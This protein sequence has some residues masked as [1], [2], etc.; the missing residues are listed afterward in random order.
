MYDEQNEVDEKYF[1]ANI[2]TGF[3]IKK[4]KFIQASVRK[5]LK[6]NVVILSHV[7]LLLV[8]YLIKL[9][10]PKTKLVLMAHG[11]EVWKPFTGYK[12]Y[13]LLKCDKIL[14]VSKYTASVLMR[15]S[16]VPETKLQALNNCLDPFLQDLANKEKDAGLLK[17]YHLSKEDIVLMT[18][19]RLAA[20][21][22][23]KGYDIVI[24]SFQKLRE[25]YPHLK[26]LIVGKY[27]EMEK[28]RLDKM[29]EKY[30]LK[31]QV[32][33]AGFIPDAKLA[34]HFNLAD[35]YIMP[36]EKEG[37]GIVFIEAMYYNKP[38]IAGNKDGSTDAL[39]GG[40]L[41]LLVNPKSTAEVMDAISK[42][43]T[44]KKQ[45]LPD[46]KLLIDNF[47]YPVYKNKWKGILNNLTR[48]Q[49]TVSVIIRQHE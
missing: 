44:D 42:I 49:P 18:V 27:D 21:E 14:A 12:K 38:V 34:D 32:I 15:L 8:G 1:P 36:S 6:N 2:F 45:F 35:I 37:F 4:L 5:G 46:Q 3:G 10:S 25:T 40:K 7:N 33:F 28:D 11:I 13:M 17:K 20:R 26:Y 30:Q 31:D 23:Y 43:L 48:L 29:I 47:S 9:F 24:E 19:A 41:G 22:R 39:L 16:Q